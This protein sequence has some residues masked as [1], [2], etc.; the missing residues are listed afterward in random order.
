MTGY[1]TRSQ[2]DSKTNYFLNLNGNKAVTK[3]NAAAAAKKKNSAPTLCQSG[4]QECSSGPESC[5]APLKPKVQLLEPE[6]MFMCLPLWRLLPFYYHVAK[7]EQQ[8]HWTLWVAL[9][10]KLKK[11]MLI[12]VTV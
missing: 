2:C 6:A 5:N 1:A 8:A 3:Q 4:F 12:I 11:S 9:T 10:K 7:Q